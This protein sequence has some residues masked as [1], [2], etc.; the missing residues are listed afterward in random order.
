MGRGLFHPNGQGRPPSVGKV[1]IG[2]E[3]WFQS[4]REAGR[5][6]GGRDVLVFSAACVSTIMAGEAFNTT[7]LASS[8]LCLYVMGRDRG[9]CLAAYIAGCSRVDS[10]EPCFLVMSPLSMWTHTQ[11]LDA[12]IQ[13]MCNQSLFDL[14]HVFNRQVCW[15]KKLEVHQEEVVYWH[16]SEAE[17]GRERGERGNVEDNCVYLFPSKGSPTPTA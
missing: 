14:P 15:P 17:V 16:V 13:V 4:V 2:E 11:N 3:F 10:L 8:D 12:S 6:A 5:S 9:R 7:W 1:L